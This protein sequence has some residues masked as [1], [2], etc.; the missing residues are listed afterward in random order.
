MKTMLLLTIAVA[1]AALLAQSQQCSRGIATFNGTYVVRSSGSVMGNP[2]ALVGLATF[3]GQGNF[4]V[5]ATG[6]FNGNITQVSADGTYTVNRDCTGSLVF[7]TGPGT[8]HYNLV[9]SPNGKQGTSIQTDNGTVTT[10]TFERLGQ[11]PW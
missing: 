1:P 9:I 2:I 8:S 5:K 4:Q 7:G 11:S 3:D 6:S 10:Q